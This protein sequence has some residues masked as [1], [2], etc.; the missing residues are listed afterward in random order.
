MTLSARIGN[1][2][3]INRADRVVRPYRTIPKSAL[4]LTAPLHK[5]AFGV[6][7]FTARNT[8]HSTMTLPLFRS[9]RSSRIMTMASATGSLV[10]APVVM[11]L[12][13][14]MPAAISSSPKNST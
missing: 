10:C 4:R 2:V 5:G 11:F 1:A 9:A 8:S 6:L 3:V 12:Q 14:T 13:D 7:A